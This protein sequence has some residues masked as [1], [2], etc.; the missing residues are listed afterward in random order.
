MNCK[1]G[2]PKQT[3]LHLNLSKDLFIY[4]GSLLIT[5]ITQLARRGGGGW[6]GVGGWV[7]KWQDLTG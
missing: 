4:Q 7:L 6:V 2:I 5:I 3:W 1:T